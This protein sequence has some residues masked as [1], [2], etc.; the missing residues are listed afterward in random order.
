MGDWGRKCDAPHPPALSPPVR[1]TTSRSHQVSPNIG[2]AEAIDSL[3]QD[4]NTDDSVLQ[5][6]EESLAALGYPVN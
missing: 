3:R 1:P 4:R 2:L 5:V 6:A